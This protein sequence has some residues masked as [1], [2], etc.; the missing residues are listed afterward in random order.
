M[1]GTCNFLA[2]VVGEVKWYWMISIGLWG[3]AMD[4]SNYG[5]NNC[6]PCLFFVFCAFV[7]LLRGRLYIGT[8]HFHWFLWFG[9][10]FGNPFSDHTSGFGDDEQR[11]SQLPVATKSAGDSWECQWYQQLKKIKPA[12]DIPWKTEQWFHPFR[13]SGTAKEDKTSAGFADLECTNLCWWRSG[14]KRFKIKVIDYFD[15]NINGYN[16]KLW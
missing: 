6:C 9:D 16:W 14:H 5:W 2:S 15:E 8:G 3:P 4:A 11:C 1:L 10:F 13:S 7:W 12:N